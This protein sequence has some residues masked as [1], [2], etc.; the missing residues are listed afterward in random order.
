MR[1]FAICVFVVC[2]LA[3]AGGNGSS[4]A[5]PHARDFNTVDNLSMLSFLDPSSFGASESD[6]GLRFSPDGS[7]FVV[8]T[9]RD[10]LQSNEKEYFLIVYETSLVR[11]FINS[12]KSKSQHDNALPPYYVGKVVATIS[13]G[14]NEVGVRDIKWL[15]SGNQL[16]FI[17]FG[18]ADDENGAQVQLLDIRDGSIRQLTDHPHPVVSFDI[19]TDATRLIFAG[20]VP[21]ILSDETQFI[22]GGS[23]FSNTINAFDP[24]KLALQFYVVDIDATGRGEQARVLGSPFLRAHDFHELSISPHGRYAV[25]VQPASKS[26]Q[27]TKKYEALGNSAFIQW[28]VTMRDADTDGPAAFEPVFQYTVLDLEQ[29][30]VHSAV[31]A[32]TGA[33]IGGATLDAVW[34][35]E[36]SVVLGNTFVPLDRPVADGCDRGFGSPATIEYVLETKQVICIRSHDLL[37]ETPR[38]VFHELRALNDHTIEIESHRVLRD[39]EAQEFGSR[40]Y[41][42]FDDGWHEVSFS[43]DP[44]RDSE[45]RFSLRQSLNVWPNLWARDVRSGAEGK[46]TEINQSLGTIRMG[47]VRLVEWTD[48]DQKRWVGGLFLPSE[49]DE[50][51]RYPLVI[52]DHGFHD[53]HFQ[54]DGPGGISASF[55]ARAL[56]S[57]GMVVLQLPDKEVGL[58]TERETHRKGVEAAIKHLD[59]DEIID[60]GK[61]G[62]IGYSG[63]ASLVHHIITFSDEYFAAATVSDG[64]SLSMSGYSAFFGVSMSYIESIYGGVP[65]GISAGEWLRQNPTFHVDRVRTP[66]RIESYQPLGVVGWWD[67]YAFLKRQKRPVEFVVLRD[68]LH[69]LMKPSE[70][71]LIQQGNVDWFDFWLTGKER[72]IPHPGAP[73]TESSLEEQYARWRV[74]KK[75]QPD[76]EATANAT[77]LKERDADASV[78]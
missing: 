34:L 37:Q 56:A 43:S 24:P 32:P 40:F 11:E 39:G 28:S 13:T 75:L 47:Q 41:R 67:L 60:P 45:L 68:G 20:R 36:E 53:D 65:W 5:Q 6:L 2:F 21:T 44:Q 73:E 14:S 10:N 54:T 70:R 3:L 30:S 23:S 7:R 25:S 42:R 48:E 35:S 15:E 59:N 31:D 69:Q 38:E 71:F 76:S 49:Y 50:K 57:R 72:V 64:Y 52:Q 61:V 46:I 16:A 27:F 17:G 33:F 8:V 62:L 22:V 74:L 9:V 26:L 19:N 29:R 51:K 1:L 12:N 18:G 66:L 78:D 4:R 58:P 63:T 55:A 77:R